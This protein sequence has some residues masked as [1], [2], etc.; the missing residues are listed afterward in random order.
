MAEA[1]QIKTE[2]QAKTMAESIHTMLS[3]K[4]K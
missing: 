1:G 4:N 3:D 2:D